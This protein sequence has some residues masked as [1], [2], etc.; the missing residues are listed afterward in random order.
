MAE[1]TENTPEAAPEAAPVSESAFNEMV[2]ANNKQTLAGGEQVA[3]TLDDPKPE[4]KAEPDNVDA[5]PQEPKDPEID[6]SAD[7]DDIKVNPLEG[8]ATKP[9]KSKEDNIKGLR[10][11]LSSERE[12]REAL[13]LDLKTATDK[14]EQSGDVEQLRSEL[15]AKDKRI[16][17]LQKYE[18][19]LGLKQSKEFREKYIDGVDSLLK[20]AQD[21]AKDY[22]VGDDVLKQAIKTGNRKQLN[23]L[24]L[25][26][27]DTV[28]IG[29][30]YPIIKDMQGLLIE[31]R[32][33]E[34][35]PAQ[36]HEQLIKAAQDKDKAEKVTSRKLVTASVQEAWVDVTNLYSAKEGG[37]EALQEIVGN[38]EHNQNRAQLLEESSAEFGQ[39]MGTFV[40]NGLRKIPLAQS[41]AVAARF[42]LAAVAGQMI[43]ENIELRERVAA[44]EKKQSKTTSYRRPMS[45]GSNAKQGGE[46]PPKEIKGKDISAHVFQKATQ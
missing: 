34:D 14:L 26:H 20:Q 38:D 8:K 42:Q 10:T 21:I 6:L 23:E 3:E 1:P 27:F 30:M 35:N 41:K 15:E 2:R 33:V 31:K 22:G 39:L 12:K 40:Q 44:L 29:E 16:A 9:K 28:A 36:A 19:L 17:E 5:D 25:Q 7:G 11:A 45:A 32:Q 37:V 4:A 13:E 18:G 24:L 43:E 46:A